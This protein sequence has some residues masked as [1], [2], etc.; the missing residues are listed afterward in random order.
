MKSKAEKPGEAYP[1][2]Y[3]SLARSGLEVQL[4]D[5]KLI[6]SSHPMAL[7][8]KEIVDRQP[9]QRFPTRYRRHQLGGLAIEE[10]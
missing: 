3:A 10:A 1:A 8:A 7:G 5:V 2:P 4:S 9:A 6:N